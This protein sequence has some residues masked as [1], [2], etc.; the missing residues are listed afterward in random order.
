M[1]EIVDNLKGTNSTQAIRALEN[2]TLL[3][4]KT[5]ELIEA[6]IQLTVED[7]IPHSDHSVAR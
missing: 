5:V 1:N 2:A 4:T 3:Q 7:Q 6:I